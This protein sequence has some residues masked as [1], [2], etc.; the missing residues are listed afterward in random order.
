MKFVPVHVAEDAG[1][2]F[3]AALESAGAENSGAVMVPAVPCTKP[4]TKSLLNVM[5][6]SVPLV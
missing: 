3:E 4:L 2:E 1:G 5:V 6:T